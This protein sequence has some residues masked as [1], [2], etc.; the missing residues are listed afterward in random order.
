MSASDAWKCSI[1]DI[2]RCTAR[3]SK[4][5]LK[6]GVPIESALS[7]L[8]PLTSRNL[9]MLLLI[10]VLHSIFAACE[11]EPVVDLQKCTAEQ[12]RILRGDLFSL[13][14]FLRHQVI[15]SAALGSNSSN[16]YEFMF[17][18]NPVWQVIRLYEAV[19]QYEAPPLEDDTLSIVCL[20]TNG[21]QLAMQPSL[22]DND[23]M[24]FV[25]SSRPPIY[26]CP[27]YWKSSRLQHNS[28]PHCPIVNSKENI[29]IEPFPVRGTPWFI[30]LHE[31]M[32]IYGIPFGAE[33]EL[34]SLRKCSQLT[35]IRQLR[36]PNNFA[37]FAM[38]MFSSLHVP[39][40]L[41]QL[42]WEVVHARC[43]RFP[44][45]GEWPCS[46]TATKPVVKYT[47]LRHN[48]QVHSMFKKCIRESCRLCLSSCFINKRY[49]WFNG[50]LPKNHDSSWLKNQD[51][52]LN[53][54]HQRHVACP[55]LVFKD[56]A[57]TYF[58]KT[59]FDIYHRRNLHTHRFA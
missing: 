49:A 35:P 2:L 38:C 27:G 44:R 50:I 4:I 6:A 29:F 10:F 31:L 40:M 23:T 13:G 8:I 26:L 42:I 7:S 25:G 55:A 43:T 21:E 36:N 37:W 1:L 11:H 16:G 45:L 3:I 56:S 54:R 9:E 14:T 19:L 28:R 52:V 24:A 57:N 22:C 20:G 32:H 48:S 17:S 15:P 33:N 39:S 46:N 53:P 51:T 30:L 12:S 47:Q 58:D 18:T 41:V 59:C 34:Y 5:P